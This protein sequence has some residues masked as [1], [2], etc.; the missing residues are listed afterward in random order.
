MGLFDKLKD[1]V[2]TNFSQNSQ[3]KQPTGAYINYEALQAQ[4]SAQANNGYP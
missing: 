3:P 1:A 2:N 4:N